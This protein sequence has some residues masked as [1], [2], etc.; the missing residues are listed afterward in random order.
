MPTFVSPAHLPADS[1]SVLD[2]VTKQQMDAADAL[3]APLASPTFT[4]TVTTAALTVGGATT[5]N[6]AV[7]KTPVALT[8]AATIA[9]DASL[10]NNFTVTLGGNRTMGA[11]SNATDGQMI[12]FRIRQDGTGSRTLAWN[13][14]YTFG[15]DITAAPTLTTTANKVDYVGFVYD[16][17]NSH[18]HLLA[19]NRGYG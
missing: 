4:G 19:Y 18:W 16:G 7:V 13:A 6:K 15:T 17:T 8:D 9:V 3:K 12:L 10:G 5:F 11:P 1:A 14:I 2:A